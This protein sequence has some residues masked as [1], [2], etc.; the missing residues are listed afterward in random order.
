[1]YGELWTDFLACTLKDEFIVWR[2]FLS[3]N[4]DALVGRQK[5]YKP[6]GIVDLV[7]CC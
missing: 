4:D 6:W 1:M 2:N 7:I 3:K 5:S